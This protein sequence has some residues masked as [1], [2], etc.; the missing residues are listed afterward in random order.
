[1]AGVQVR[2]RKGATTSSSAKA[3]PQQPQQQQQKGQPQASSSPKSN[4]YV[5]PPWCPKF[6]VAF[7]FLLVARLLA[8]TLSNISDCDEVFNYWEPTHFLHYG[9]GLQTWEYSPVYAIRSWT[10]AGVH[11]IASWLAELVVV[12]KKIQIFFLIRALL[13]GV[14]AYTE[15]TLYRAIVDAGMPYVARYFYIMSLFAT[16]MSIASTAYLPSTFSMYFVTLAFAISLERPSL[17][18]TSK[19]V[20]LIATSVI[21]GWP[22]SGAVAIPFLIE[23]VFFSGSDRIKRILVMAV[24]GIG[25]LVLVLGPSVLIDYI[26]YKRWTIVPLNIVLYNVFSGGD[27]GPDIYG[28]EPWWF[29]LVNGSLN[30][31]VGFLAALASL[32]AIIVSGGA[33]GDKDAWYSD[34]TYGSSVIPSGMNDVN[35]EEMDRYVDP[36]TCTYIVDVDFPLANENP[37]EPRYSSMSESWQK[38]KCVPFLDAAHSSSLGRAFW[39][40]DIVYETLYVNPKREW[41]EYCLLRNV[42]GT[43]EKLGEVE[44]DL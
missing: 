37:E 1:M 39:L 27:K 5:R 31:N 19:Y 35:R 25:S 30:F 26:F 40:P 15:A 34:R 22:F 13:G 28:T 7:Q 42:K 11:A 32:P 3:N 18:R 6:S 2:N 8:A 29:Y 23:D 33:V 10:Y 41:G 24:S 38:V 16:G 9:Y 12:K 4:I 20:C 21:L 17:A 36:N 43:P 14:S 44:E